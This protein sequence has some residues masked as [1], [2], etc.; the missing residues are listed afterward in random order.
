MFIITIIYYNYCL[1]CFLLLIPH[2]SVPKDNELAEERNEPGELPRTDIIGKQTLKHR[3]YCTT[4]NSHHKHARS[5][6][7]IFLQA[8]HRQSKDATPHHTMK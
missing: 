1:L 6:G 7:S 4:E 3:E 2:K 8:I 5:L